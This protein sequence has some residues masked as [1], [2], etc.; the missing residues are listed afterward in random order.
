MKISIPPE[1]LDRLVPNKLF[2]R[3][4]IAN[5][6]LLGYLSLSVLTII[7]VV[8]ALISLQRLNHIN[9]SIVNGDIPVQEAADKM[10][11][12]VLAQDMYEKRHLILRSADMRI[13]FAKRGDEFRTWVA[14]VKNLPDRD[15]RA[16]ESVQ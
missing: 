7:V 4:T 16:I 13:L 1:I 5:K 3:L 8:Y 10:L 14:A 15:T 9:K 11:D 6:M 12:A 2:S